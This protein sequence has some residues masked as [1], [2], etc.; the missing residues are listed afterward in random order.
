[1]SDPVR[2]QYEDLPYPPRDPDD[3]GKRLVT[4]SPSHLAEIEHYVCDG[5]I[6]PERPFRALIAGGG[7]GDAAI[8]L[9]QQLA[10]RG[11]P[12]EIVYLDLS[13]AS[14]AI[15]AA[16]AK[17][18]GL[19]SI[20]FHTGS[21]L[22]LPAMGLA[23]FDYIDCC[24]VLHHLPDP[25]A[26]LRALAGALAPAGG[27]GL[28]VYGALGRTGVYEAQ[29]MLRMIAPD[30]PAG[31]TRPVRVDRA[32]K[33]LAALPPTNWLRR[34]PFIGDHLAQGDAGLWDLLLHARDR[35]YRVPELLALLDG[36][37]LALVTFIEPA[38]Y[39]PATYL[40]APALL[41]ALRPLAPAE[42]AGFAEL[43]AG[44]MKT[45]TLYAKRG[46]AGAAALDPLRPEA[47]PVL[48]DF[49]AAAFAKGW[50]AGATLGADFDGIRVS[51]PLPDL[52]GPIIGRI[53]GNLDLV[54]I[55]AACRAILPSLDWDAFIRAFAAVYAPMNGLN[56]LLIRY[57]RVLTK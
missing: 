2:D 34:N 22:D 17:R 47:V 13:T 46:G 3:E 30:G 53:D 16:R 18:R 41:K 50:K 27:I 42:R 54:E 49:D 15:C 36:A 23:P 40:R 1:M 31:G 5:R 37:G 52:A 7:T 38:R 19:A 32:R 29:A 48:K 21:L 12:A 43:L 4:G 57:R 28:M 33:L 55:H 20:R 35:A 10:D 8:M 25:S 44:N 45:H 14:R 9:A 56:K 24:G 6:A 26:G 51:F 11:Q 39:D